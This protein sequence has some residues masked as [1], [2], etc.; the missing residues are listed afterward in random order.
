ML[1]KR[2]GLRLPIRSRLCGLSRVRAVIGFLQGASARGADRLLIGWPRPSIPP[3][4]AGFLFWPEQSQR[5]AK[6]NPAEAGLKSF[7][8]LANYLRPRRY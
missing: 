3:P 6:R 1:K 5:S 2:D 7:E 4:R 8:P